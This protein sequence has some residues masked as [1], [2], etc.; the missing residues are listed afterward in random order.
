MML[1]KPILTEAQSPYLWEYYKLIKWFETQEISYE[2]NLI[3]YEAE[4][5]IKR[6][7]GW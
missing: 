5:E 4:K 2:N 6:K 3:Y 7:A 1:Q